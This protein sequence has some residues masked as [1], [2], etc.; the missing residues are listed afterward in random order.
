MDVTVGRIPAIGKAQEKKLDPGAPIEAKIL[1]VRQP[2]RARD[3]RKSVNS[4]QSS[5]AAID[6]PGARVL[7][8]L[9]PDAF[10][11]PDDLSSGDYRLFL[12][13]VKR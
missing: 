5:S 13:I 4:R 11:L 8:L 9:V 6:P 2:R 1:H 7:V 12:R 3:P 10:K